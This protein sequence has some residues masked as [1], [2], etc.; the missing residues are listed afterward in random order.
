MS[1]NWSVQSFLLL[2]SSCKDLSDFSKW[3]IAN[4]KNFSMK[5]FDQLYPD[6]FNRYLPKLFAVNAS[7]SKTLPGKHNQRTTK[8][9]MDR[10]KWRGFLH[11]D[12]MYT[13]LNDDDLS[14]VDY[15]SSPWVKDTDDYDNVQTAIAQVFAKQKEEKIF[16]QFVLLCVNELKGIPLS[17]QDCWLYPN[18]KKSVIDKIDSTNFKMFIENADEVDSE[19]LSIAFSSKKPS[20]LVDLN[21]YGITGKNITE[22]ALSTYSP[23]STIDALKM[24][25]KADQLQKLDVEVFPLVLKIASINCPFRLEML[26]HFLNQVTFE[27]KIKIVDK[28]CTVRSSNSEI[29]DEIFAGNNIFTEQ[30]KFKCIMDLSSSKYFDVLFKYLDSE[31]RKECL[32]VLVESFLKRTANPS[33]K[34]A[35]EFINNISLCFPA[36][37][38]KDIVLQLFSELLRQTQSCLLPDVQSLVLE[39]AILLEKDATTSNTRKRKI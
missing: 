35:N 4:T 2:G 17:L 31:K 39:R 24:V 36:D 25:W 32:D 5:Q 11:P 14:I 16:R 12:S 21:N 37:S 29:M 23:I 9:E 26:A 1:K 6:M 34:D 3:F 28:I 15:L 22:Y 27:K 30:E 33:F 7:I 18:S 19:F 10:A 20:L 13:S 38:K 8:E